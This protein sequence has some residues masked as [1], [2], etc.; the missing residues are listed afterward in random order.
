MLI[1]CIY[2]EVICAFSSE[3]RLIKT[4][5]I[6]LIESDTQC[7]TTVSDWHALKGSAIFSHNS[8]ARAPLRK[9]KIRPFQTRILAGITLPGICIDVVLTLSRRTDSDEPRYYTVL[10][11]TC[12]C[13]TLTIEIHFLLPIIRLVNAKL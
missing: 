4:H 7:V 13:Y 3:V 12:I 10:T 6:K 8:I 1:R 2:A 5:V 11:S 9:R